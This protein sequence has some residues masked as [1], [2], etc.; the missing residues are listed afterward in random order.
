MKRVLITLLAFIGITLL[1]A[2]PAKDAPLDTAIFAG[3]CFWC[4]ET[5]FE[6]LPGVKDVVSGYSGGTGVNPDYGNYA[7]KGHV[8][9]VQITYDPAVITYRK[10]LNVF[11][12]QINPTD[13][14]GQFVDRGPQYRPVVFY[15][16]KE[17]KKL[18]EQSRQ[19][20]QDSGIYDK[21]IATEI[22]PAST[23]YPAE[24]YHQNY[25][26]THPIRYKYYRSRSG[27]DQ[28]LDKI[29]SKDRDKKDPTAD[30]GRQAP[31][32]QDELRKK[33]TPLQYKVTQKNGTERAFQNEYW[34]N[35]REGIYV[36]IVSGEPLFSSRDKYKSGTGWPSF[37]RPLEPANIVEKDDW[38]LFRRRTEVRSK[39]ADSHLGHVFKDGPAPTGLRYCLNS[40]ALRF[41]PKEDLEKEGYGQYRDLFSEKSKATG[42]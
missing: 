24:D 17:Q 20:L 13:G 38:V 2:E 10:L 11:W 36:D 16:D 4:M 29:W 5:P 15:K 33:L 21:P 23:F 25:H 8:E 1:A 26:T 22:L 41:V 9:V 39:H 31:Y 40:A 6:G 19:E 12:R 27:R 18:A 7:A 30:I 32:T 28:Y 3:G 35:H 34:D 42:K 14:N 37:T